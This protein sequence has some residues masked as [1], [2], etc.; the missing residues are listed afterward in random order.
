MVNDI[1]GHIFSS[2]RNGY[3]NNKYSVKIQ[4]RSLFA[5]NVLKTLKKAGLIQGFCYKKSQNF[6]YLFIFLKYVQG[7]VPIMKSILKV[8]SP[9]RKIQISLETLV[10]VHE[11][12]TCLLISTPVGV[13][14]DSQAIAKHHGGTLICKIMLF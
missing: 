7:N 1:L 6:F 5:F 3:I 4:V 10:K 13:L 14:T 11:K 9:G 8:S 12:S 2:I